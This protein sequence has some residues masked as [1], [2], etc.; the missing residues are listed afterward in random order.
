MNALCDTFHVMPARWQTRIE[1]Y[2]AAGMQGQML[3]GCEHFDWQNSTDPHFDMLRR[4]M[5]CGD[6]HT[7]RT[8][9][10]LV[11]V[12]VEDRPCDACG[13][14]ASRCCLLVAFAGTFEVAHIWISATATVNRC[15]ACHDHDHPGGAR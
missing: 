14:P 6:C 15:D 11:A 5:T 2:L 4:S 8:A 1:G 9:H 7:D 12:P 13:A 3:A 10:D